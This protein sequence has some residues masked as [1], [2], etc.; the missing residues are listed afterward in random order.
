MNENLTE[1]N[2]TPERPYEDGLGDRLIAALIHCEMIV[3]AIT[4]HSLYS[5]AP[6]AGEI[7]EDVNAVRVKL[8]KAIPQFEC[9]SVQG[10]F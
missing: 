10:G 9:K 5:E 6:I 3:Q 8:G 7:V 4:T 2:Q 1:L